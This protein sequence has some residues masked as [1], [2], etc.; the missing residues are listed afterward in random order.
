MALKEVLTQH[1]FRFNKRYGQNF[2]TDENLLNSI[3]DKSGAGTDDFVLEIG[4]GAGTLT[5]VIASKTKKVFAYEIDK[6]LQPVL[7]DTLQGID[8]VEVVF[9][10]VMKIPTEDI[11]ANIGGNYYI[12][13]NLP[14]YITTPIIMKF[15]EQAKFCKGITVMVQKEV[16]ERLCAQPNTPE[17]GSITPAIQAFADSQIILNVNRRLF[18]PSPNVDSAVVKITFVG[19]RYDIEDRELF[20]KVVRTAFL[21]RR[22]TLVNNLIQGFSLKRDQAEQV[23][24]QLNIDI[25]CRGESLSS[26]D[27]AKISKII[28]DFI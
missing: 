8:N 7:K 28:K 10:D 13:A 21:S 3:V 18:Y 26:Q 17:Y 4:A 14:Y 25:N 15:F 5:R 20:N 24:R 27:F 11:E 16:A 22:K 9:G 1:N 23:L 12:I 2:L 6:N 19:N